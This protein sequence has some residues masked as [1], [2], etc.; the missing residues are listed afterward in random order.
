MIIMKKRIDIYKEIVNGN[1]R[2]AP[3]SEFIDMR[4]IDVKEG[5]STFELDVKQQFMNSLGTMQGGV[6]GIMADASMGIAFGTLL[7][8]D[9]HFST[10][11]FKINFFR[12][13]STGKLT[14]FGKVVHK[15]K[16]IGYTECEIYNDEQ[17]LIAKS[18][19]TQIISEK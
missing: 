10:A 7:D 1:K 19:G 11:E 18:V 13:V 3:I 6:I 5:E 12:P 14:S 8:E 15:G 17:K 4:L 9:T 2:H 16:K